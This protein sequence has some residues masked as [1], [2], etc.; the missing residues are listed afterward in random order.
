V[1]GD[2][3]YHAY[4][5]PGSGANGAWGLSPAVAARGNYQF[6]SMYRD[7]NGLLAEGGGR[8]VPNIAL[9]QVGPLTI[10]GRRTLV[11]SFGNATN[12]PNQRTVVIT[13]GIHAR[14]WIAA[15]IAYLIAEYLIFNYVAAPTVVT[16]RVRA[17]RNLVNNR[18]IIIIPMLNPDGIQR[19]VYGA[20]P[21]D[22]DWR[23]NTRV[24]PTV[25]RSWVRLVAPGGNPNQPYQNV[26]RPP[27]GLAHYDVPN[28]VAIPAIPPAPL[29]YGT[30]NL[31]QNEIGV[32][33]NRNLPTAAYGYD[34]PPYDDS[35]PA[36]ETFHGPG[37]ASEREIANLRTAVVNATV[38]GQTGGRVWASI[39][40]HSYGQKILYGEEAIRP[41]GL[42]PAHVALGQTLRALIANQLN[43]PTYALQNPALAPLLGYLPVG[44][45]DDYMTQAYQTLAFTVELDPS[46]NDGEDFELAENRI[47][48]CFRQNIRGAL[49][50]IRAPVNQQEAQDAVNS[51]LGWPVFNAGNQVP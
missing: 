3:H 46:D 34:T 20:L 4:D 31:T 51:F 12:Q 17:L 26:A 29:V 16:Q 45:V 22:R 35:D 30:V 14:E 27:V 38:N 32:D 13:G 39:D 37:G 9:N 44:T 40:Y 42:A 36:E 48:N 6:Y 7:L 47:L 19:T 1:A 33:L 50:A 11:L 15:E 25:P 5:Y 2:Y 21:N 41:P 28:Y 23:K 18:N 10:G 49:A 43:N 24:L 8:H